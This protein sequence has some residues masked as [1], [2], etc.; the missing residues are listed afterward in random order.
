MSVQVRPASE[1]RKKASALELSRGPA[2]RPHR[3]VS[4]PERP[5][6]IGLSYAATPFNPP[7]RLTLRTRNVRPP[8][9]VSSIGPGQR[10]AA[11]SHPWLALRKRTAPTRG[12]ERRIG[13]HEC[14]PSLV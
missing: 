14:P 7:G 13:F 4:R 8:S 6:K 11:V 3:V 12:S 1:V 2:A 5:K 9:R 10:K